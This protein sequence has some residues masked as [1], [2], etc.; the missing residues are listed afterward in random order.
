MTLFEINIQ[1][2]GHQ[3]LLINWPDEVSEAILKEMLRLKDILQAEGYNAPDWDIVM[4]YR[5]LALINNK[6]PIHYKEVKI[7]VE[8]YLHR[9]STEALSAS[10]RWYL[11]VCYDEEFALDLDEICSRLKVDQ[12]GLIDLHT[13]TNYLV[14]GIGFVPGFMYLGGLPER[15]ETQRRE[16]PRQLVLQGSVGLAGKQTGIYPQDSPGGWNII[17]NCPIPL[18]SL[19]VDPPCFVSVGD[20][21]RFYA[22]SKAEHELRKIEAKVG[23][24]NLKSEEV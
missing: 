8:V 9:T 21:I 3:A 18:F 1:P 20:Q 22:I 17:G 4:A 7:R 14:Y 2:L 5:S 10:T 24:Y 15:L 12:Q 19:A 6:G 13:S 11:P 23:V 16:H